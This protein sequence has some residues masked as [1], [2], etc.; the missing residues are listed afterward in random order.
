M[1]DAESSKI[2]EIDLT[3]QKSIKHFADTVWMDGLFGKLKK[4]SPNSIN[5]INETARLFEG[6][7]TTFITFNSD[8]TFKLDNQSMLF[9]IVTDSLYR[10]TITGQWF[11]L[12]E[13][14]ELLLKLA[15]NEFRKYIIIKLEKNILIVDEG[16]RSLN[17]P[18]VK[19]MTLIKQ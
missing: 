16:W 2:I 8:S 18:P 15:N 10:N 6:L 19:E 13:S 1:K 12:E 5:E 4:E 3:N 11:Y 7:Q 9:G 17:D 14:S